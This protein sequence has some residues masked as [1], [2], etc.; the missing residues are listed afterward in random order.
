MN[1]DWLDEFDLSDS[2]DAQTKVSESV[3]DIMEGG[4]SNVQTDNV[5]ENDK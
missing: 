1:S 2:V 5:N 4:K 3:H